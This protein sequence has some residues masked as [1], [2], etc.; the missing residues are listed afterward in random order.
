MTRGDRLAAADSHQ[1]RSDCHRDLIDESDRLRHQ[2]DCLRDEIREL[3]TAIFDL[4]AK[5][6]AR[7]ARES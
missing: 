7:N 6:D 1:P 5:V 2:L 4:I 3:A